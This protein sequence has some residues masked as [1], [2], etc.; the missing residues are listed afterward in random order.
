MWL[1]EEKS[2]DECNGAPFQYK[3][4][5]VVHMDSHHSYETVMRRM[6]IPS[7]STS[8][9]LA[10]TYIYIYDIQQIVCTFLNQQSITLLAWTAN[11]VIRT[12]ITPS[13]VSGHASNDYFVFLPKEIQWHIFDNATAATWLTYKLTH[14]YSN[15]T[16]LLAL[17]DTT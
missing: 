12:E 9:H 4:H 15:I 13:E 3:I 10:I 5:P 16:V 17:I 14:W 11:D 8:F 6:P 1:C 2:D 7:K